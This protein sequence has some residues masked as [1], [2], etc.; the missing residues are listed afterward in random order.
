MNRSTVNTETR[1]SINNEKETWKK[2]NENGVQ[3]WA[4]EWTGK[5]WKQTFRWTRKMQLEC[6]YCKIN[7]KP[8]EIK[9]VNW[10]LH[11]RS[12]M[13]E[14][15]MPRIHKWTKKCAIVQSIFIHYKWHAK[16]SNFE[17]YRLDIKCGYSTNC[18]G[19]FP[20]RHRRRRLQMNTKNT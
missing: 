9:N 19:D 3:P 7:V 20:R 15:Q 8:E 11:H 10:K 16:V 1:I 2:S 6:D 12:P 18:A 17:F 5:M 4:N 13:A 14:S